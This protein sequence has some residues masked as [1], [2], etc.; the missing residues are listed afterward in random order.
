MM[1]VVKAVTTYRGRDPRDFTLFAYGGN[2]GVHAV[3]LARVL[4]IRRVVIPPGAGVFSAIGLLFS[5]QRSTWTQPLH[6]VA[7]D[8]PS[9]E[10]AAK[11]AAMAARIETVLGVPAEA[12]A[13]RYEAD[14]RFVGQAFEITVPFAPPP[15]DR[16]TLAQLQDAFTAEHLARYGHAFAGRFPVEVV[17]LR[18][19]GTL[20]EDD[21][22]D[23]KLRAQERRPAARR[24]VHFGPRH[25]TVDTPIVGRDALA[26]HS[27]PGPLVIEEYEGTV[28]VPPDCGARRDSYG[29][30]VIELPEAALKEMAQ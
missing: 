15:I 8:F 18:L 19:T 9:S 23:L 24:P 30:I 12:V 2:G 7:D 4:Q 6:C 27:M 26:D 16:A 13:Y 22:P 1:R 5:R 11:F 21:P 29:N 10:A 28:V 25:G 20:I 17:N 14:V 3:D